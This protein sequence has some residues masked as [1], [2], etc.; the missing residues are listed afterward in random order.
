MWRVAVFLVFGV[1][2]GAAVAGQAALRCAAMTSLKNIK[3]QYAAAQ[4]TSQE[5]DRLLLKL[6]E[7]EDSARLY[8]YLKHPWPR[9][10]LLATILKPMPPE[11]LFTKLQI[12]RETPPV[13]RRLNSSPMLTN[14]SEQDEQDSLSGV[15][16]D[17][18]DIQAERS[19][20]R[21]VIYLSGYTTDLVAL[22]Q[23]LRLL[24]ETTL[25]TKAELSSL[26]SAKQSGLSG[27]TQ[28]GLRLEV[29]PG[30]G[31]PGGPHETNSEA[32]ETALTAKLTQETSP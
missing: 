9:T 5:H 8:A 18:S 16:R 1:G 15:Q 13:P 12:T 21:C 32:G 30:Y 27:S 10:Q 31:N 29:L 7:V 22:H 2:I 23:Y 3:A 17:L 14:K 20:T 25:I 24:G 4:A 26:T 28:F 11:V 19:K 6:S